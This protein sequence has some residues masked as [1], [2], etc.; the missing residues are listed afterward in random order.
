M[1]PRRFRRDGAPAEQY[2]GPAPRGTRMVPAPRGTQQYKAAPHATAHRTCTGAYHDSR[3]PS[4]AHPYTLSGKR[5]TR[6]SHDDHRPVSLRSKLASKSGFP[7]GVLGGAPAPRASSPAGAAGTLLR[8]ISGTASPGGIY[9]VSPDLFLQGSH[10]PAC[11]E[12]VRLSTLVSLLSLPRS[13]SA[14]APDALA[15]SSR[16]GVRLAGSLDLQEWWAGASGPGP[17]RRPSFFPKRKIIV[18]CPRNAMKT[19]SRKLFIRAILCQ[20]EKWFWR[21]PLPP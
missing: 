12:T 1:C 21:G 17:S 20:N 7:C 4:G 10:L 8:V 13:F 3:R 5:T 16:G 14:K 11:R 18:F 15:A 6:R 9:P 19:C 2:P